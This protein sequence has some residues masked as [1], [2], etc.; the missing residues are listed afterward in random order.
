VIEVPQM[1]HLMRHHVILHMKR[2]HQQTP[3]EHQHALRRAAGPARIGVLHDHAA[4]GQARLASL[5]MG[6]AGK[7][8][9]GF[10]AQKN[11]HAAGEKFRLAGD[12]QGAAL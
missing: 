4:D 7:A 11:R 10:R 9:A 2:G 8:A 5:G 3:A 1:R 6:L 12:V